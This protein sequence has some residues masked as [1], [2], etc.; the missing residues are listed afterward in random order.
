MKKQQQLVGKEEALFHFS[1][2]PSGSATASAC[3]AQGVHATDLAK[4]RAEQVFEG[5]ARG[6]G[7]S[8]QLRHVK[9]VSEHVDTTKC[10]API[11]REKWGL[12]RC[13]LLTYS[14]LTS[15]KLTTHQDQFFLRIKA[16]ISSIF[17]TRTCLSRAHGSFRKAVFHLPLPPN[18]SAISPSTFATRNSVN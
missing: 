15:M 18:V 4:A 9:R 16:Y 13:K 12:C 14:S 10:T 7:D 6:F 1:F 11:R 5:H 17:L 3:Q 2:S 8:L